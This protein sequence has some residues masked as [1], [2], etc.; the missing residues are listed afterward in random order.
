MRIGIDARLINYTGLGTYVRGLLTEYV[1]NPGE[2]T[3]VLF[4]PEKALSCFLRHPQV[5]LVPL[6]LKV[7]SWQEQTQLW[8]RVSRAQLDLFHV[9][10]FSFPLLYRGRLVLTIHDL[11]YSKFPRCFPSRTARWS[12]PLMIRA[13][14]RRPTRLIT[15]SYHAQRDLIDLLHVAPERICV[16]YHGKGREF[17]PVEDRQ[18]IGRVC[19]KYGLQQPFVLYVGAA[20]PHKNVRLLLRAFAQMK[21][22]LREQH[23]LVLAGERNQESRVW[24]RDS[25]ALGI[26]PQVLFPGFVEAADLPAVYSAAAVLVFPSLHEGFGLPPIE[27]MAC[28]TPVISSTATSLPEVLGGAAL[29]FPPHSEGALRAKLE[30]VLRDQGVRDRLRAQGLARAAQF[31]WTRSAEQTR[32]VY[33]DCVAERD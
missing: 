12:Y 24:E 19:R 7:H 9:P 2:D 5:E 6:T 21:A 15:G 16:I 29:F 28:G 1:L 26:R 11:F 4:G 25:E 18:E 13:A 20:A 3:F 14:A 17:Q 23:Q 31:S 27:A 32:Q 22:S 10:Y 8:V 30:Q 33:R